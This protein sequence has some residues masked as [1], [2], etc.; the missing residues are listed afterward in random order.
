MDSQI[1]LDN[2]G[3][4]ADAPS[5]IIRI[6]ELIIEL[7]LRGQLCEPKKDSESTQTLLARIANEHKP[8][9]AMSSARFEI[10]A[11]WQWVPFGSI[12][13]HQ[14]GKMLNTSKTTGVRRKYLRTANVG[15]QGRFDL[16]NVKEMLIPEEEIDKYNVLPGDLFVN[17]GGD[18]GKS[19]IWRAEDGKDFAF[20]NHLH[21]LRPLGGIKSEY[22]QLVLQQARNSGAIS[23]A[24]AGVTIQNFS[25]RT[26]RSL[27]CPL[28]PVQEQED[29]IER[30]RE[31]MTLC[32]ELES[33]L[34]TR[35]T[36]Q[37]NLATSVCQFV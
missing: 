16:S 9:E 34:E 28:P 22:L 31:L 2:F 24:S 1:F 20:Q 23:A 4:I 7:A 25:A 5:G 10:P 8:F 13:Q 29:I 19:A 30:V 11:H 37:Q 3:I 36:I 12:C 32:D 26:L 14:L 15:Q 6:R 33:A 35:L 27:A 17:E 18:V 21:R